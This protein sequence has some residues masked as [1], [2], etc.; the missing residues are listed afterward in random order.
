MIN[1][2]ATKAAAV[3]T[4]AVTANR[5]AMGAAIVSKAMVNPKAATAASTK[6]PRTRLLPS[7]NLAPLSFSL[8]KP[9]AGAMF[10]CSPHFFSFRIRPGLVT[11]FA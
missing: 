8:F 2:A 10:V 7:R 5:A 9:R 11:S 1:K 3:A 6:Q 4:A